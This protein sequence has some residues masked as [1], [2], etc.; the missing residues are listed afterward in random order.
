MP[1]YGFRSKTESMILALYGKIRVRK[2]P[3]SGIFYSMMNKAMISY[4]N[5]RSLSCVYQLYANFSSC[6]MVAVS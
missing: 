6:N 2:N 3:H 4:C 5:F 1:E